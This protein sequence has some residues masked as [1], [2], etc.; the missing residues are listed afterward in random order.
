MLPLLA[1]L[2]CTPPEVVDDD[3]PP[4]VV[5]TDRAPPDTDDD[6]APPPPDADADGVPDV[7]DCDDRDPT[8]FPG[9]RELDDQRDNDCDGLVDEDFVVA[10]DVLVTEIM[11]RPDASPCEWVELYNASGRD[12]VVTGWTLRVPTDKGPKDV[13]LGALTLPA[14]GYRVIATDADPRTNGGLAVQLVAALPAIADDT[15]TLTLI[16]DRVI[17]D[18]EY[19]AGSGLEDGA[20][21]G[22][23]PMRYDL[24]GRRLRSSWCATDDTL[25]EGDRGSPGRAHDGCP[26]VDHDGD[27]A[28]VVD[29][30]C[31]DADPAR[32]PDL[33][34]TLDGVDQDCNDTV[35]DVIIADATIGAIRAGDALDLGLRG[36]SLGD[37]DGDGLDEL[38]VGA[39]RSADVFVFDG[40]DLI[41][42]DADA[43]DLAATHLAGAAG[44]GRLGPRQ[45]DL[46]GD[47]A[48][49]LVV[50][51]E[52]RAVYVF[53]GPL[54]TGDVDRADARAKVTLTGLAT[55][56]VN[57]ADL[58]G[59]GAA[60]LI[61]ADRTARAVAVW[62]SDPGSG[63]VS[64]V[65]ADARWSVTADALTTG[66][67]DGDG[68]PEV[69]IAAAD[70]V[71]VVPATATT[72]ALRD[73]A[74]WT[75]TL[76]GSVSTY[77]GLALGD[78]D[79]DGADDLFAGQPGARRV[80]G[81][82]GGAA[83]GSYTGDDVGFEITASG[84]DDLG[85]TVSVAA[86]GGAPWLLVAAPTTGS[87]TSTV[88]AFDDPAAVNVEQARA[89]LSGQRGSSDWEGHRIAV[90]DLDGDGVPEWAIAAPEPEVG[91]S[92]GAVYLLAGP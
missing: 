19:G 27:G 26:G 37:I 52:E 50:G 45:G 58:D 63:A 35:D 71:S 44:F 15:G 84:I 61:V 78:L 79:G 59:D 18:A 48:V 72:G 31:D 62:W 51:G 7:D 92:G 1:A 23:D 68:T 81:W 83:P 14:G 40:P 11:T 90:G 47:G 9:A 57:D 54:S 39:P 6:T 66:D 2:A 70:T 56:V 77:G 20:S 88:V 85:H 30:D 43:V 42:A 36:L 69:A 5:D 32:A 16:A 29:G 13:V 8:T 64:A 21:I 53:A 28:A 22:L 25:G 46:D 55:E 17:T 12:V 87:G 82:W 49:D 60:S 10:D 74:R 34:E 4:V 3:P 75:V 86:V 38:I 80:Q 91:T 67:F 65:D 33:V 73:V 89:T 24:A 76:D 41:G